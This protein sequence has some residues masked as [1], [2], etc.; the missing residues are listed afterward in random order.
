M[1]W[2]GEVIWNLVFLGVVVWVIARVVGRRRGE[3]AD[4]DRPA[5][6]RR[7]FVYG[8]LFVTLM[9]SASGA[10]LVLW[11]LAGVAWDGADR[12]PT[13]LALGLSLVVVAGPAYGLLMRHVRGRLAAGDSER[14]RLGWA[15][16]LNGS[17][18]VSL[19]VTTVAAQQL[20]EG[21]TG[22]DDFAVAT[23]APVVVF[24]AVWVLHWFRLRPA[25]GLTGDAYPA[26]A[27]LTGLVTLAIG[28]GGLLF[29]AGDEIY[30]SVVE[31]VPADH[32]EP[33][34]ATWVIAAALG[35]VIWVGHWLGGY[36]R[37]ERTPLWHAYVV[38][39]GALGGLLALVVSAST[40]GN[41][42]LVWFLGDAD[43]V[44]PSL[45][46]EYVPAAAA[47]GFLVG[48]LAW[49]YH[50]R[51]LG[52]RLAEVR[53]GPLRTYDYLMAGLGLL[54]ALVGVVL[55]LV[56]LFEAVTPDPVGAD[57][58]VANRLILAGTLSVIGAPLW[59]FFWTRIRRHAAT[60]PEGELGSTVRRAY[61]VVL[62]GAGGI[63]VLVGLIAVVFVC[64]ED[65]LDGTFGSATVRSF[66]VGAAVVATVVGV[67]WYHLG[68][69]RAD[70][71][72][73]DG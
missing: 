8:L 49:R 23:F 61:L 73:L 1:E 65:L 45:H 25:Y 24:A 17:L 44:S 33:A 22:V 66:R 52:R 40:I 12:D 6:M 15:A 41:W 43:E 51:V 54:A 48:V 5:S 46:F 50:R 16:Y 14:R 64:L 4:G 30:K 55:A 63:A 67:A 2:I 57:T 13:A 31:T 37:A 18:L 11:E 39:V 58:G 69:F 68:V 7:L 21:L 20:F 71:A 36:V 47:A 60:D 42:T 27:S 9:L 29:V 28:A 19:V 38:L 56:A 26:A 35:A 32:Y 34:L 10:A 3:R 53:T 70:R 59:R 72:D 62:F